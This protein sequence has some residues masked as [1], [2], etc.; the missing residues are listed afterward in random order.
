MCS[1]NKKSTKDQFSSNSIGI[2]RITNLD[3]F[4]ELE[5]SWNMLLAKSGCEQA[6]LHWKWMQ[7]WWLH[8][9]RQDF[10]PVVLLFRQADEL[11]AIFPLVVIPV[12]GRVSKE[13]VLY[14]FGTGENELE[15]ITTEYIDIIVLP[16]FQQIVAEA[17]AQ[18]L[19]SVFTKWD[20]MELMR[21]SK[22]SVLERYFL[23]AL[24]LAGIRYCHAISGFR[25]FVRLEGDYDAY[26]ANRIRSFRKSI[27]LHGNRLR[28][29]GQLEIQ[30][31][32]SADQIDS[33]INILR[34]LHLRRFER[35]TAT[36]AF[37]SQRFTDYHR[38]LMH[39]LFEQDRLMFM[40]YVL[41]GKPISAEYNFIFNNTVYA[42][43]GSFDPDIK[44]LSL[45]FLSI[46]EM[47]KAS[48]A[49]GAGIYDFMMGGEKHYASIYGCD[50]EIICTCYGFNRSIRSRL[51]FY[52]AAAKISSRGTRVVIREIWSLVRLMV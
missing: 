42:Y 38:D 39:W 45:G 47:I 27:K 49:R 19:A 35:L 37:I 41:D 3:N 34:E 22:S 46:N 12:K 18:Y 33:A 5:T 4:A 44:R 23:P 17:A 13:R 1:R 32:K 15:E 40:M 14:F 26:V 11:V 2:E 52:W 25:H 29:L 50:R 6:C 43:Q 28:A 16:E 30:Q 24:K 48:I 36:S 8:F 9:S 51:A 31:I 20:R 10:Q 7:L 21:Y